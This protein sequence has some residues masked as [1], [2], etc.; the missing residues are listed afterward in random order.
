MDQDIIRLYDEYTHSPLSR[1]EFIRRLAMLA[2]STAAAYVL[3][4][5][6]ENNYAL[7]AQVAEQDPRLQISQVRYPGVKGTLS[8]YLAK[9]V[10]HASPL[11]ALILI[12]EN[13]G[14]N[15]H[16]QDVARRLALAGFLTL[17][18]DLLSPL[19]GTPAD[20]DQAREMIGK[21]V[22][23]EVVADLL[24]TQVFLQ[25]HADSSGRVGAIGFCWGGGMCN[26]LA[27]LSPQLQAAVVYYGP[28]PRAEQVSGIQ[29][30][31]LLHYAGL[32]DRINQGVP[33]FEAALKSQGKRYQLFRYPDVDH[34][35]NNDTNPARYNQAAALLAWERTLAFLQQQLTG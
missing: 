31:L 11:P 33:A 25:Q 16:I 2:G 27:C 8:G 12:H 4:P 14:L 21:L 29:A 24:A 18:P 22:T 13:R 35:F 3:L 15:P 6:L 5:L 32:D 10:G 17:A 9:P 20:E 23:S 34:A 30:P 1:R 19:G 28:S 26:Q 7:A